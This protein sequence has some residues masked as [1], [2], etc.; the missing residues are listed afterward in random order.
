MFL[1]VI[2]SYSHMEKL[3]MA[4]ILIFG[5]DVLSMQHEYQ[6]SRVRIIYDDKKQ[7]YYSFEFNCTLLLNSEIFYMADVKNLY[8]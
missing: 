3:P 4:Q 2:D 8:T 7:T 1:G 6:L 5:Q